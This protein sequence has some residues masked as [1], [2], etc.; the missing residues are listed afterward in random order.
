MTEDTTFVAGVDIGDRYS[1]ICLLDK[2]GEVMETTRI[3]TTPRGFE[4]YFR[5]RKKMKVVIEVGTHSPWISRQLKEMGHEVLVANAR[6]LRIIYDNDQKGDRTDAEL[7]ARVARMDP[8]LLAPIRHRGESGQ[9]MLAMI[10]SRDMLVQTRTRLV[11]HI[12][13]VVKSFGQRFPTCSTESFHKH[14]DKIPE[15]LRPA[16]APVMEQIQMLNRR[17]KEYELKIEQVCKEEYPE[18]RALRGV[19]GVGPVTSLAYVLTLEDPNRFKNSRSVGPYLGFVPR[20][21]QTGE[22]DPQLPITKAG[23]PYL[24]RLLVGSAHY[25]LGPF[26]PDT[27]LRRWGLRLAGRGGKNAKKRSTVAVARKLSVLLYRL[28][29]TGEA[30]QPLQVEAVS[31]KSYLLQKQ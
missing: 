17:L 11:N 29:K 23:D 30:Y 22:S 25:I 14:A 3:R 5:T 12:R 1:E 31:G 19:P 26:G 28:W 7:L 6:R 16:L 13:G 15:A 21:N 2:D 20:R 8:K 18:T 9:A 27:D 10:R 4:Q 24:R